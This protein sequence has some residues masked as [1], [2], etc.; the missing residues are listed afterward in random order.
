MKRQAIAF[1]VY[2]GRRDRNALDHFCDSPDFVASGVGERLHDG[3]SHS[4]PAGHR[5][6]R[7]SGPAYSGTKIIVAMRTLAGEGEA[8]GKQVG[9]ASGRVV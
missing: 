6:H 1:G 7:L 8:C 5:H 3:R 2:N 4:C 9:G